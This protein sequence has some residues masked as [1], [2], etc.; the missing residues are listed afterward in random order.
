MMR[1]VLS[2]TTI[3]KL[4]SQQKK[5]QTEN[6]S[7]SS[8]FGDDTKSPL[9]GTRMVISGQGESEIG[10]ASQTTPKM[11]AAVSPGSYI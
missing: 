3:S 8:T 4:A 10:L 11:Q 9:T 2:Q 1:L 6:A 7:E 5:M